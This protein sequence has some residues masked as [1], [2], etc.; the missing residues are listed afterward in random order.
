MVSQV[1][2]GSHSLADDTLDFVRIKRAILIV[3]DGFS[4][5]SDSADWT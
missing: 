3:L 4:K 1:C 5:E 2:C